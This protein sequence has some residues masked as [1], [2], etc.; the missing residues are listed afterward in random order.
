MHKS[1][2]HLSC[3]REVFLVRRKW[4]DR[5]ADQG[6]NCN[7]YFLGPTIYFGPCKKKKKS[8]KKTQ[9]E[10]IEFIELKKFN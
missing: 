1:Y 6:F 5:L 7:D 2:V 8:S 3:K 9:F 4:D 10:V